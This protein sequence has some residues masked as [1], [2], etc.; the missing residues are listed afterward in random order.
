[1]NSQQWAKSSGVLLTTHTDDVLKAVRALQDK[2]PNE[3]PGEWWLALRYAA[4]LHDLGKLDPAFQAR[5]KKQERGNSG[6]IPHSIFSLFFIKPERFA[7]TAPYLAHVI[8]SAVAFHHWRDNF[9]DYLLGN[10][11]SRIK[12]KAAE[13]D[14]KAT[15][16]LQ[17]SK[18]LI[19]E[20]TLLAEAHNLD[21]DVMGLNRMLVEYLRYN[22]LGAAGLLL[23]PYTLVYLPEQ[24]RD[25]AA[26]KEEIDR[27]RIFIAGNLM[28]ADH[29]ASM[30]EES[31]MGLDI[32]AIES[33]RVFTAK[34]IEGFLN[35]KFKQK[36]YWQKAFFEK[37]DLRGKNLVLVAPT[38]YG[39]TEFAYLWG[40]GKKNFFL[41]PMQAAVNKIW[42][43]TRD[44]VDKI[45]EKGEERVSLLHSDAALE[46]YTHLKMADALDGESNTRKV[47]ELARHLARTYII[48][49]ADQLA[50]A[51]LRYP[52]YERIFA[53]LMHGV[54]VIDEVQ[55]YD[56]R[57]AAIITHLV[58]QN[59]YLGGGNL[60]ITATLPSFIREEMKRRMNL[61]DN[62]VIR[63]I[64][65]PEF[66]EAAA[67]S[68]HR[69]GFIVHAG[70]YAAAV[71]E[72]IQAATGGK[73]VLVVMN[74]VS[75]ACDIFDKIVARLQ[76]EQVDVKIVLLHSRFIARQ[77]KELEELIVE[78]FMPN[79]PE[80]DTNPCIVVAT[81]I[82][83][84]SLDIDADILFT[85]PSPADSLIQRM[86]RVFRRFAR[87]PGDFAPP[88]PNV[89][90]IVNEGSRTSGNDTASKDLLLAS[91][92]NRVYNRDLTALSTV[93]LLMAM[94]K[95]GNFAPLEDVLKELEQKKWQSCFKKS[96]NE[97]GFNKN[98]VKILKEVS[99]KTLVLTERQKQD[100]VEL[101][102]SVISEGRKR[103]D[104][105]LSLHDYIKTYEETLATL[106][107]GYCS[108]RKRDAER[109]FR[110]VNNVTGIPVELK[111]AF[112]NTI[113]AWLT[114]KRSGE[115]NFFELAIDILPDFT[116]SC[117]YSMTLE[118]EKLEKLDMEAMLP[119]DIGSEER[120][121][122]RDKLERWLDGIFILEFPYDGIKGLVIQ[123]EQ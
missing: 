71:T 27:A 113:R 29:F 53:A 70:E 90:V 107:H 118:G 45:G 79:N 19:E 5:I 22:S 100:W 11:E 99:G 9:P 97:S 102:Y 85:E 47:M 92:L 103:E 91:G 4:L 94:E 80:R 115:L 101:T 33:G 24:I 6:D 50:P 32:Q 64:D 35:E 75:A 72:I 57:A 54:L 66:K 60:I 28:R 46:I 43:R 74:T 15:E 38:G 62:Q 23:P 25:K 117:P 52:G 120:K 76:Q 109:L 17:L 111:E 86:G 10:R 40:A 3:V 1:M 18:E 96:K 69:L 26:G 12:A 123:N 98:L 81:Q 84:A 36:D 83:E 68:R 13:L 65:E 8:I 82:V 87:K 7:F 58:Q 106:D 88:E 51:A 42:Q 41:L 105:K 2:L 59:A 78:K 108:D 110:E 119:P 89:V 44:M 48:A 114:G 104:F 56:P 21:A 93:I 55:A 121:K 77:R 63:L 34:E 14:E 61:A 95:G 112:Y 122:L 49:T 39:K 116:V 67:S 20:L 37:Y 73:K 30:V 16:W 31:R